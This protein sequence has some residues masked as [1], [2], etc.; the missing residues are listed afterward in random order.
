MW[1]LEFGLWILELGFV[2]TGPGVK[3][4]EGQGVGPDVAVGTG[5]GQRVVQAVAAKGKEPKGRSLLLPAGFKINLVL[6]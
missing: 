5:A 1:V 3:A 6:V 2:G 4:G